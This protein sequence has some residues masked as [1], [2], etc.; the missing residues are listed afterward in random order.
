MFCENCG[1]REQSSKS[2]CRQCGKWIGSGPP[3]K[4]LIVMIIFN[5]ISALF[6]AAA[7]IALFT[8]YLGTT[9]AKWSIYVAGTFCLIISVYQ[10]LSF[11]FAVD[12]RRRLKPGQAG[13]I[14]T[15]QELDA[16]NELPPANTSHL[17]GVSSVIENTTELLERKPR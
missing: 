10:T 15:L 11:F 13:R 17:V 2:Y 4:R 9:T 3:E 8:T 1:A 5:A 16:T 7:A 14:P 6:G 12:L